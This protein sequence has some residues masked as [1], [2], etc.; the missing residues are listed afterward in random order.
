MADSTTANSP[1][2]AVNETSVGTKGW[3]GVPSLI[4]SLSSLDDNSAT[5]GAN[6]TTYYL[7]STNFGFSIP[8]GSMI[9]GILVEVAKSKYA[10][11]VV[12]NRVRIVKGG[13]IGLTDKSD[14]TIW[15]DSA[16]PAYNDYFS[17][18]SSSDLWGETW[19]YTDINS[20][21]FG[22]AISAVVGP[23]QPYIDHI[24]ITVTYT[25]ASSPTPQQQTR[26]GSVNIK[27]GSVIIK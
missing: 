26:S 6:A 24:R 19:T 23:A 7:K 17:Y 13:I 8:A 4:S 3:G 20:S 1:G 5:T 12:D 27:S 22:F 21:D 15:P 10:G 16:S 2:T 18:G 11:S 9:D 25:L 14:A